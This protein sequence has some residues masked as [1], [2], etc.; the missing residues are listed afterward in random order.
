MSHNEMK[1]VMGGSAVPGGTPC[2]S[3][4]ECN[5]GEKCVGIGYS[6][7]VCTTVAI[8]T[9]CTT[10]E[11]CGKAQSCVTNNTGGSPAKWCVTGSA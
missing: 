9:S 7:K 4:S 6:P 3:T 2:N 5:N 1:N 11:D 8:G 10:S